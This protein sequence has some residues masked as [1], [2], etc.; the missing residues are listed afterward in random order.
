MKASERTWLI[1]LDGTMYKGNQNI[2][3]AREFIA[4]L[5]KQKAEYLFV[6]NNATRT[7]LQNA[8]HMQKLGFTNICERD[9]FTS[10]M[11]SASY[12][13]RHFDQR[14]AAYLGEA[15]MEEALLANHFQ[16]CEQ[17][18]DFLFVGLQKQADF[19]DYSHALNILLGGAKLVGTNADRRLPDGDD[20]LIGNGAV[21]EMLSYASEQLPVMIGKPNASM[22]EEVMLYLGKAKS[23]C[24]VLGDNLE[25]DIAFGMNN[26]MDTV[27]VSSGVH[28]FEDVKKCHSKPYLQVSDLY[29]LMELL[30]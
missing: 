26:E 15:G 21:V 18:A 4:F 24:I 28:T 13:A 8:E 7:C 6:T 10:S 9:F 25:T 29:E 20:Y 16:I 23:E 27:F 11:A 17:H 2:E 12:I 14:R 30:V 3:G 22:M 5:Q 1:D 19:M